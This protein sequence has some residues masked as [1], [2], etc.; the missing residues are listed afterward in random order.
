MKRT[1]TVVKHTGSH[2]LLTELPEWNLFPA[3]LRG[4]IRLK[5][6]S[7][8]N[9]VAVGDTVS[10]E[11]CGEPAEGAEGITATTENPAVITEVHKRKNYIIRRSTNL[12]RQAHIIAANVDMAFI[13]ITLDFPEV[14]LPFLDRLLVTCEVYNVPV[15]IVLNKCDLYGDEHRERLEAFHSIYEGAG[16]PIIE[17]SAKTGQGIARL[18]EMLSGKT[19]TSAHETQEGTGESSHGDGAKPHIALFS[20]VS[21]VGKSSLIKALDP[22][23]E[24]RVGDISEAHLQ[25][26]HTTTFYEMYNLESGGFIIDTPGIRGFGLVDIDRDE[27]ALYFP[28]MLEASQECRF[29]PCTHTH[30]PGCAVKE[31]VE[32]GR[33]SVERYSSYLGMLDEEGKYR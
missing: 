14:K 30:E 32:S 27:I 6:S 10:Y 11:I 2:Y 7:A 20:G 3:V 24:P 18:R 12:S 22:A 16:Y 26:K 1:A 15:T 9:P 31:A 8:T 13:V 25:G 33:I 17:V 29:T 28:E 4:K 21:G 23:L 19:G 5:G